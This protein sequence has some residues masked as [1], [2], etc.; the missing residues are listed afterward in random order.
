MPFYIRV[1]NI[2]GFWYPWD[3]LKL[4]LDRYWGVTILETRPFRLS[5][6]LKQSVRVDG[7]QVKLGKNSDG[8]L[9]A[10]LVP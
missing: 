5:H 1:L 4:T 9:S 8:E 3:V 2:C 7:C 6:Y 10:C